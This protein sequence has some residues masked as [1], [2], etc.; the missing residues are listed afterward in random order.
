MCPQ[1]KAKREA[2]TTTDTTL[3]SSA[4]SS[5]QASERT[6]GQTSQFLNGTEAP[7]SSERAELPKGRSQPNLERAGNPNDAQAAHSW[8][9]IRAIAHDSA[10][11]S[12]C[13]F[14]QLQLSPRASTG[15]SPPEVGIKRCPLLCIPGSDDD[16]ESGQRQR[17]RA[18]SSSG[19]PVRHQ[20]CV[21]DIAGNSP[22]RKLPVLQMLDITRSPI[23][24]SYPIGLLWTV[25]GNS[26]CPNKAECVV[27]GKTA[28]LVYLA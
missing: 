13:S 21:G 1:L 25:N 9:L 24:G 8:R 26:A 12:S 3:D 20:R 11:I 28:N 16:A 15:A 22:Y 23:L 17:A 5:G 6:K 4:A 14:G 19:A 7:G 10:S 2:A 27:C 18:K